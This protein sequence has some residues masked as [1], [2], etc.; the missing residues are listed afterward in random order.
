VIALFG[1]EEMKSVILAKS[2]GD[3]YVALKKGMRNNKIANS[4]LAQ[5]NFQICDQN[6]ALDTPIPTNGYGFHHP[7]SQTSDLMAQYGL[8]LCDDNKPMKN[9]I[10]STLVAAIKNNELQALSQSLL[11]DSNQKV[12]ARTT[13]VDFAL[14]TRFS[15]RKL[16]TDLLEILHRN[17]Q[18]IPYSLQPANFSMRVYM[19]KDHLFA[20]RQSIESGDCNKTSLLCNLVHLGGN[21]A[22]V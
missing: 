3:F 17:N 19:W 6:N 2:L 22:K 12:G 18:A 4:F 9:P 14:F 1:A 21:Q 7:L 16:L 5:L 13:A 20:A 11:C 8:S 10:T 15:S